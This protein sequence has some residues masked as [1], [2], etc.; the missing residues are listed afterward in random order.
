M[1]GGGALG[2]TYFGGFGQQTK[3]F[4]GK[5]GLLIFDKGGMVSKIGLLLFDKGAFLLKIGL[6]HFDKYVFVGKQDLFAFDKFYA[7]FVSKNLL[8]VLDKTGQIAK[9]AI[10]V[11]SKS[12]GY[13][14]K[15][16]KQNTNYTDRYEKKIF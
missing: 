11:F 1:F 2:N 7:L 13:A 9:L 5:D 10:M 12:I 16:T 14:N 3:T 6:F 15:Y 4:V 8:T